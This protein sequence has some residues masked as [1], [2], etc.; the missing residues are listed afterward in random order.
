M[1][2]ENLVNLSIPTVLSIAIGARMSDEY[3]RKGT[4]LFYDVLLLLGCALMLLH[5]DSALARSYNG[6]AMWQP[7]HIPLL[8]NRKLKIKAP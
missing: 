4:L 1:K 8:R 6:V 3:G 5:P 2:D 7:S